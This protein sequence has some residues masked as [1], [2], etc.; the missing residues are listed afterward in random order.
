M[1]LVVNWNEGMHVSVSMIVRMSMILHA[2]V[3]IIVISIIMSESTSFC[4]S[5]IYLFSFCEV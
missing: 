4:A 2:S 1:N 5:L 3:R